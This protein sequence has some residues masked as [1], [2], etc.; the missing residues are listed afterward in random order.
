MK[1]LTI[2]V[3]TFAT[4]TAASAQTSVPRCQ[5]PHHRHGYDRQQRHETF[6][7]AMGRTTGT[8]TTN[9]NGTTTFRDAQRSDDWH[10]FNA[11]A[12]SSTQPRLANAQTSATGECPLLGGGLNRSTQHP[13]NAYQTLA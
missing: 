3:L 2:A 8:A 9:S 12:L 1:T 10:G 11:A 7:D 4:I 6:R 5:R 13:R